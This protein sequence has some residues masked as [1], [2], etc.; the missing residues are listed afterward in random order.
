MATTFTA[1]A[2]V[3]IP[4][5]GQPT[6]D[7]QNIPSTYTDLLLLISAREETA[8]SATLVIDING[9][10]ANRSEIKLQANASSTPT[11]S[12]T[13]DFQIIAEPSNFTTNAFGSA[14]FYIGGYASNTTKNIG[15]ESFAV[16]NSSNDPLSRMTA[17]RWNSTSVIDRVTIKI[18]PGTTGGDINQYSTT[19]LYGIKNTV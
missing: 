4:A 3:E 14:S 17:H 10:S 2:T 1:I 18:N 7:F 12:S 13:S 11:S 19:T 5:G 15:S 6:I 8:A 16:H 9:S